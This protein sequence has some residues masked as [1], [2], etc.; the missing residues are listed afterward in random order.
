MSI[1]NMTDSTWTVHGMSAGR[2]RGHIRQTEYN[3]QNHGE[4]KHNLRR[5]RTLTRASQQTNKLRCSACTKVLTIDFHDEDPARIPA[6]PA[7]IPAIAATHCS[8]QW[9]RDARVL[10]SLPLRTLG[11]LGPLPCVQC[12]RWFE[13]TSWSG[14]AVRTQSL[15]DASPG[16]M[17][18]P[19]WLLGRF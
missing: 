6:D 18:Q 3:H 5:N 13:S 12:P 15:W 10:G 11:S 17:S 7:Q 8:S 2:M 19:P 1:S 16:V 4:H 14:L 9:R